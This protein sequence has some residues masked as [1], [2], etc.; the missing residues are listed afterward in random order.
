MLIFTSVYF[1]LCYFFYFVF[2]VS[3]NYL[4]SVV[5][6]KHSVV[7]NCSICLRIL[8]LC[9]GSSCLCRGPN[10]TTDVIDGTANWWRPTEQTD[11]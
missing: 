5:C 7:D 9:T 8:Q 11:G 2:Q 4:S 6:V 3:S 10:A 1:V